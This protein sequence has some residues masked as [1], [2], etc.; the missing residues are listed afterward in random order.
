MKEEVENIYG[1]FEVAVFK[2][3]DFLQCV[4][5]WMEGRQNHEYCNHGQDSIGK[6]IKKIKH[7]ISL[8]KKL[9]KRKLV[10]I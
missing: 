6:R 3:N 1:A 5:H 7:V 9:L 8:Y 10:G 2:H 4:G